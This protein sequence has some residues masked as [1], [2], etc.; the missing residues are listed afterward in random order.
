MSSR[1]LVLV[2]SVAL[3][4][5]GAELGHAAAGD[6]F[7]SAHGHK[8]SA[9]KRKHRKRA[10]HRWREGLKPHTAVTSPSVASGGPTALVTPSPQVSIPP[11]GVHVDTFDTSSG[12]PATDIGG[13]SYTNFPSG[14]GYQVII[15]RRD[16]P[17]QAL[18]V[19]QD[20]A[21]PF[22]QE[23][24]IAVGNDPNTLVIITATPGAGPIDLASLNSAVQSIGGTFISN[25][26]LISG[27]MSIIGIPGMN[28]GEA[29]QWNSFPAGPNLAPFRGLS[30]YLTRDTTGTL[31]SSG[32]IF[33]PAEYIPFSLGPD[34]R[35]MVIGCT[36]R[37]SACLTIPA[38]AGTPSPGFMLVT[39]DA[40]SLDPST[41]SVTSY[42]DDAAGLQQLSDDLFAANADLTRLVFLKSVGGP[43][44]TAPEWFQ[45]A[46]AVDALGGNSQIFN[47]LNPPNAPAG[48]ADY[49]LVGG[50]N[51]ATREEFGSGAAGSSLN[52][53][54]LLTRAIDWQLGPSVSDGTGDVDYSLA[55]IA[56]QPSYQWPVNPSENFPYS[57][58]VYDA[59]EADIAQQIFCPPDPNRTEPCPVRPDI[60][61]QYWQNQIDW[62][63]QYGDLLDDAEPESGPYTPQQFER[64]KSQLMLEWGMVDSVNDLTADLLSPTVA[65]SNQ[66]PVDVQAIVNRIAV[67][68]PPP[69]SS[70]TKA[71]TLGVLADVL[72]VFADLSI[73]VVSQV[74]GVMA[75][76]VALSATLTT[77]G[78]GNHIVQNL[79]T[80]SDQL[81]VDLAGIFQS[82]GVAAERVRELLT[83]DWG[84][85][86]ATA[87]LSVTG[88]ANSDNAQTTANNVLDL[89]VRRQAWEGLMPLAYIP[90]RGSSVPPDFD[91]DPGQYVCV[92]N[93]SPSGSGV[94][95]DTVLM[96]LDP[97]SAATIAGPIFAAPTFDPGDLN[98]GE[99]RDEFWVNLWPTVGA[100]P[101]QEP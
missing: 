60:R 10:R 26:S 22:G 66:V 8:G 15:L 3:S 12:T 50:A 34:T 95:L 93:I 14:G 67:E 91:V 74:V 83:S 1:A 40:F 65:A 64:L 56:Y 19:L 36:P 84:K 82:Q 2:L 72:G 25:F 29:Y 20:Q 11:L 94:L 5:G 86:Q 101:C 58:G 52:M 31:E 18:E 89:M 48:G 54:G 51:M 42:A 98:A 76:E 73:P 68:V 49:A 80:D 9:D 6:H 47:K 41:M 24:S 17:G 79:T 75:G 55:E 59:A 69:P 43:A 78:S 30:G 97:S 7:Q 46:R 81:G 27:G 32:F 90:R 28:G 45:V 61:A 92:D 16:G 63:S 77:D 99:N 33:A 96:S 70:S 53:S 21:I 100:G 39:I 38:P 57:G 44:P 62:I 13:T 85:L 37:V 4:L 35:Q 88:L 87:S 23:A 71:R